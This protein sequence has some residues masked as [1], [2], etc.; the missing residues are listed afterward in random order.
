MLPSQFTY[1][2]GASLF[3]IPWLLIFRYRKDLRPMLAQFGLLAIGLG[4]LAEYLWWT[5]DW[6]QPQTV[7]N[8]VVGIE[9]V[10]LAFGSVGVASSLFLVIFKKKWKL[11]PAA[12]RNKILFGLIVAINL[13][14]FG[15][16]F[17]NGVNS[18]I[19]TVITFALATAMLLAAKREL[20]VPAL[21]SG[22]L[23]V[24]AVLPV[25]LA[26][27]A[28]TPT[29]VPDTWLTDNL[30]GLYPLG[31]PIEDLVFYFVGGALSFSAYPFYANAKLVKLNT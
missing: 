6:W 27:I 20:V 22:A 18:F 21:L 31:I 2:F 17:I 30:M 4:L 24:A 10:I 12:N 9:D 3:L 15:L 25:F 16:L 7:T 11:A 1:L 5:K 8:T 29:Y 26:M 14:L 28:V 23:M 19:S 13:G